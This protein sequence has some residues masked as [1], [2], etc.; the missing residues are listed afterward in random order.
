MENAGGAARRGASRRG[1][2]VVERKMG[3]KYVPTDVKEKRSGR[4]WN[5]EVE[6]RQDAREIML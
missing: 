5:E 3:N 1:G 4:W 2:G 6:G